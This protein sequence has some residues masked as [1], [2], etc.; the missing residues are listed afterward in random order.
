[1][2][3][4]LPAASC[5]AFRTKYSSNAAFRPLFRTP[6]P[7]FRT[8]SDPRWRVFKRLKRFS[9]FCTRADEFSPGLQ[10]PPGEP[11]VGGAKET[12]AGSASS[13]DLSTAFSVERPQ[14]ASSDSADYLVGAN[15]FDL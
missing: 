5:P 15:L 8:I 1:M 9:L 12:P 10:L 4:S 13:G 7:A 11:G 2:G 14:A 3:K 6:R